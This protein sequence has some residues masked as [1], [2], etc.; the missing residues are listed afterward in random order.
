MKLIL[1]ILMTTTFLFSSNLSI[2]YKLYEKQEYN[3]ACNYAF[4]YYYKKQNKNSENYLTFYGLSCLETNNL[5][6]IAT[7]M[8][9]LTKSED[10]RANASYFATILLQKQ[11]LLQ[12]LIDEK[13]LGDVYL[14]KTNFVL[15]KVFD[16]FIIKKYTFQNNIY[17]FIDEHKKEFTYKLYMKK[18]KKNTQYMILD[19]Y[20]DE[21][22]TKRYQYK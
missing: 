21:K 3:K 16:L 14:P 10:A 4:K 6:R 11:L 12:A 17:E 5:S 2:L 15:S 9:A 22:F 18:N 7:P 8:V 20:K 19:I 13:P 1:F